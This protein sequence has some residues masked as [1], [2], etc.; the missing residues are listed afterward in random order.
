MLF[1]KYVCKEVT[2]LIA[3]N[4]N[5]VTNTHTQTHYLFFIFFYFLF[6][7]QDGSLTRTRDKKNHRKIKPHTS[8]HKNAANF[9]SFYLNINRWISVLKHKLM[10][11]V[12]KKNYNI[13]RYTGLAIGCV[14][15]MIDNKQ[16][17]RWSMV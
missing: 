11:F 15:K 17:F 3:F 2:T 7:H 8:T 10:V 6:R 9:S 5:N 12:Q 4:G 16:I 14:R 1:R 13:F